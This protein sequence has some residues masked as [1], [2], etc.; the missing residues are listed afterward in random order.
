[1]LKAQINVKSVHQLHKG[2]EASKAYT[3]VAEISQT[4][5]RNG[6]VKVKPLTRLRLYLSHSMSFL[7][8]SYQIYQLVC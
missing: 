7:I 8:S 1:M 5:E 4:I 2:I 6:Q 3:S